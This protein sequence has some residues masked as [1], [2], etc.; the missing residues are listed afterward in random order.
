MTVPGNLHRSSS[1]VDA[2]RKGHLKISNPIPI[3]DDQQP[4]DH[5][6]AHTT[7]DQSE[8]TQTPHTTRPPP[9]SHSS[10]HHTISTEAPVSESRSHQDDHPAHREDAA[11]LTSSMAPNSVVPVP[12]P[13]AHR[14]TPESTTTPTKKKRKSGLKNVFRKMFGKKDRDE[15]PHVDEEPRRGHSYHHSVRRLHVIC[16]TLAREA[17]LTRIPGFCDKHRPQGK[18]LRKRL[19]AHA[20]QICQSKSCSRCTPWASTCPSP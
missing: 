3:D 14:K 7:P 6:V 17:D 16:M 18:P 5:D 9:K 8:D 15:L 10:L 20:S 4:H 19:A 13:T 1:K 2:I 11:D 12:S